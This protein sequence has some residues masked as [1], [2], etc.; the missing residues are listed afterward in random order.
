[1]IFSICLLS[2][3][4][5]NFYDKAR[6]CLRL[7]PPTMTTEAFP[8]RRL[9]LENETAVPQRHPRKRRPKLLYIMTSL[10]EYDNGRRSTIKGFDRFTHTILPVMREAST[11]MLA[12]GFDV[13]IYL[14]CHYLLRPERLAQLRE[15]IPAAADFQ[16]WD[17]ATPL[18]Y[19]IEHSTTRT[20]NITRGLSRQHRYVIKDKLLDYDVFVNFEDDMLIKGDHVQHFVNVTNELYRLRETAPVH[21]DNFYTVSEMMQVFHGPMTKNQL[22]RMIPGFIRVEAALPGWKPHSGNLYEQIPIDYEWNGGRAASLNAS[23]CCHVSKETANDHIPLAPTADDLYFWETSIDALGIRKLPD[24]SSLGWALLQ[25]GNVEEWYDDKSFIIGDY[26]SGRDRY[27]GKEDR[28]PRTKGR[29]LNNQGG[30]MA[31][32]RQIWE[33]HSRWCLGGFLPPFDPRSFDFDGLDT[34][35]VEYWSGGIQL[36]G[37]KSCN[38]QRIIPLEP[39]GFSKQ[40]LYHSSNNKQRQKNVQHRFSS[41]SINQFWGQ[42][43]TVRKNA[44]N[45]MKLEQD[46]LGH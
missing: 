8:G 29:Y 39:A 14:I 45:K 38:L 25:V 13:H 24:H 40:L 23:A 37:F 30:W 41:R 46:E 4:C 2:L 9:L 7:Q 26:W 5:L 33:W 32:R 36:F 15:A 17:D 42:L 22:S 28:P 35:S 31:T 43:N 3:A 19:A 12:S 10:A 11:S 20:M 44:E 18:G 27:Y 1:M 21:L 16:F 34:R 6:P